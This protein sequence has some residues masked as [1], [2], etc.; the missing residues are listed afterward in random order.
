VQPTAKKSVRSEQR[1]N[2][3]TLE[4]HLPPVDLKWLIEVQPSE[5]VR[6]PEARKL[7]DSLLDPA[8]IEA[9]SQLVGASPDEVPRLLV[10]GYPLGTIYLAE[11]NAIAAR[12][13]AHLC[14]HSLHCRESTR[15][16]GIAL[17]ETARADSVSTLA[18]LDPARLVWVENDPSLMKITLAFAE[19]KSRRLPSL[20]ERSPWAELLREER[21]ALAR[22]YFP[23]PFEHSPL[24]ILRTTVALR[25]SVFAVNGELNLHLTLLGVFDEPSALALSNELSQLLDEPL[26]RSLGSRAL[27]GGPSPLCTP[28]TTESEL[29]RCEVTLSLE[30]DRWLQEVSWMNAESLGELTRRFE[31]P[32]RAEN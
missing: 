10:A 22:V 15:P 5:V 16:S 25:L 12:V 6:S 9:F 20:A 18:R 3:R 11:T 13:A 28:R 1:Y 23:G 8:R 7:L 32:S 4:E 14:S 2:L 30:L 29:D 21:D 31:Q 19:G 17:T 26:G 24:R 27:K